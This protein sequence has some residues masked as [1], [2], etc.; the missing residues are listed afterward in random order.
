[1]TPAEFMR[2]L[3]RWQHVAPGTQVLAERG[4][5]EVMRQLQGFEAP[6]SAWE[7]QI[8]ARRI[9]AY[10]PQILDQL[11]LTGRGGLGKGVAAPG[12]FRAPVESGNG[13]EPSAARACS[14]H[15]R[16]PHHFLRA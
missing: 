4:A 16:C 13:D 5:L 1:M 2:W 3:L 6:A 12:L 14:A 7:P 15:Q 10:D 9:A 11:C 8:L